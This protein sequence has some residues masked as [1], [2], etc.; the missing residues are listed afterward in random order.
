MLSIVVIDCLERYHMSK[1][2]ALIRAQFAHLLLCLS[3]QLIQV[4]LSSPQLGA[5]QPAA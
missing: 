3:H 1:C 2:T 4:S 5:Q